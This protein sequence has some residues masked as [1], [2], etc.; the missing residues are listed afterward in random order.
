M[1]FFGCFMTDPNER[2]EGGAIGK[3]PLK[4]YLRFVFE[5][6][7]GLLK[8]ATHLWIE[9]LLQHKKTPPDTGGVFFLLIT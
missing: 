7:C 2:S 3:I 4:S 8:E 9:T 1:E 6:C 5:V